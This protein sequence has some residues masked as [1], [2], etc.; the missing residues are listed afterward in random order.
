[1]CRARPYSQIG[2]QAEAIGL[3][4]NRPKPKHFIVPKSLLWEI[5]TGASEGSDAGKF[6]TQIVAIAC[7]DELSA[8]SGCAAARCRFKRR[9]FPS[10]Y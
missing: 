4:A 7:A 1:L 5:K 2:Q 8:D 3:P 6:D 10:I 9:I